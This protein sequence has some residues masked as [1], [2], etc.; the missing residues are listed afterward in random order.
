MVMAILVISDHFYIVK[1]KSTTKSILLQVFILAPLVTSVCP[2]ASGLA[3]G[4]PRF[5]ICKIGIKTLPSLESCC[6]D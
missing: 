6:I 4:R 5:L 1:A 3:A 2:W